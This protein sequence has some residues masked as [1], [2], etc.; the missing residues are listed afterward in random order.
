[1]ATL[2]TETISGS[3][4]SGTPVAAFFWAASDVQ[5]NNITPHIAACCFIRLAFFIRYKF[6]SNFIFESVVANNPGH[7]RE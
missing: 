2:N 7:W 4:R 5:V 1:V 6:L 3:R